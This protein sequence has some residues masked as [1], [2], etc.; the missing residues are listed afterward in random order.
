[1]N[2]DRFQYL[3]GLR[4]PVRPSTSDGFRSKFRSLLVAL[5]GYGDLAEEVASQGIWTCL[6]D[7]FLMFFNGDLLEEVCS[8]YCSG[9]SCCIDEHTSRARAAQ[10]TKDSSVLER[11]R[12]LRKSLVVACV[13]K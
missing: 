13:Q 3:R 9:P 2:S 11:T 12:L 5:W 7:K 6:V 8:H 1:M 4:P 10:I